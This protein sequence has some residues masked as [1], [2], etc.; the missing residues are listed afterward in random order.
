MKQIDDAMDRVR[1][2]LEHIE[3]ALYEVQN[4][5]E[6]FRDNYES[7]TNDEDLYNAFRRMVHKNQALFNTIKPTDDTLKL[8]GHS[9]DPVLKQ[10]KEE[11]KND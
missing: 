10:L 11:K 4:E 3:T 9:L 1:Q 5:V 8:L 6:F 2:A 7:Y